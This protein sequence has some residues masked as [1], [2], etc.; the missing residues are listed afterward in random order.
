VAVPSETST[1]SIQQDAAMMQYKFKF[2]HVFGPTSEQDE[3]FQMV[4]KRM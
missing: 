2:N 1:A 3:V 4:G